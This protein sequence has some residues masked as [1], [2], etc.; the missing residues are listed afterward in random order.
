[1]DAT[2]DGRGGKM[3]KKLKSTFSD[4]LGLSDD[5]IERRCICLYHGIRFDAIN[6]LESIFQ[7]GYILPSNKVKRDFVSYD[8]TV[9]YLYISND[10]DENCNMGKYVSVMPYEDDLEFKLFV[11]ENLFFAIKGTIKA[12]E[13]THVSYDEYCDKKNKDECDDY[14]S[15]AF[16]EYF[17]ENDISLDDVIYIGIDS[18]YFNGNYD[19]IVEDVINLIN[20]YEIDIPF[21]DERTNSEIYRLNS[22]QIIKNKRR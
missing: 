11:R 22:K 15:Y 17:V 5:V 10:S 13:T 4:S 3:K 9:K 18:S 14:Y 12:F 8:G 16:N 19:K 6:R 2:L 21:V 7:T 1:M 20:V